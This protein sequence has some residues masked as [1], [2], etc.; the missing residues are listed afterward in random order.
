MTFWDM[1]L[2]ESVT[3]TGSPPYTHTL[4][5]LLLLYIALLAH[6]CLSLSLFSSHLHHQQ[7]HQ[8]SLLT[9]GR[10]ILDASRLSSHTVI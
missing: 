1:L 8:R 7:P 2:P 3:S 9:Q 4:S 10:L 5:S 6:S